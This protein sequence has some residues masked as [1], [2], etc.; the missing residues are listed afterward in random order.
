MSNG[1]S[2][3]D[4]SFLEYIMTKSSSTKDYSQNELKALNRKRGFILHIL[5]CLWIGYFSINGSWDTVPTQRCH[6]AI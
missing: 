3:H 5:N 4:L 6:H 1:K 2:G